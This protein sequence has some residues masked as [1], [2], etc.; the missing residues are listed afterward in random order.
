MKKM[1]ALYESEDSDETESSEEEKEDE[2]DWEVGNW[3]VNPDEDISETEPT[4]RLAIV[5]MD[6]S[7]VSAVDLLAALRSFLPDKRMVTKVAVYVSQY[8]QQ[9]LPKEEQE[10]PSA[11]GIFGSTVDSDDE[12]DKEILRKYE[13]S[14]LRYYYA[15]AECASAE[16]AECLMRKLDGA[17]FE[18]SHC[19]FDLRYVP[20]YE[21]FDGIPVRDEAEDVPDDFKASIFEC[22][23]LQKTNVK[24]SWDED[25]ERRAKVVKRRFDQGDLDDQDFA[26]YLSSDED[27][28]SDSESE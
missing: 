24:L 26:A 9:R 20:D 19:I 17:E 10:G 21:S 12:V 7:K 22:N 28:D 1:L 16:A 2:Y 15:V 4:N 3:A 6:W 27:S 11:L 25:D 23:A 14:K 5:D 13:R 18:T 8:G